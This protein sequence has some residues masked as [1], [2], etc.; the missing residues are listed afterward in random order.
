MPKENINHRIEYNNNKRISFPKKASF[1]D[2]SKESIKSSPY[3]SKWADKQ[4]LKAA[5]S[6]Y[7]AIGS[8]SGLNTKI[9]HKK[10][11]VKTAKASLLNIE[12]KMTELGEIIKYADIYRQTKRFHDAYKRSKDPDAYLRDRRNNHEAKLILFDSAKRYLTAHGIN[13]DEMNITALNHQFRI[14]DDTKSEIIS[15][16]DSARKELSNLESVRDK[17]SD[18]FS[19]EQDKINVKSMPGIEDE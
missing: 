16:L 8:F 11:I 13:P 14:L 6:S 4:N 18:Y 17:M 19:L 2:K 3:L 1:I 15:S 7:A 12:N 10:A 5:S 9:E